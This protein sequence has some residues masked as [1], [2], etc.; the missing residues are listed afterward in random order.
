MSYLSVTLKRSLMGVYL[1][2]EAPTHRLLRDRLSKQHFRRVIIVAALGRSNG[3]A[4]GTR[5]QWDGRNRLFRVPH[6]PGPAYILHS[7]GPQTNL[8]R[9]ILPVGQVTCSYRK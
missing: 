8:I 9:S 6:R 7:A 3:T 4:S 1:D 5:L 2:A